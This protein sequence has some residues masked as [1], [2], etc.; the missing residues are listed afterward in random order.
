[1]SGDD[2][3]EDGVNALERMTFASVV[4]I[5]ADRERRDQR[6]SHTVAH[7]VHDPD[8]EPAIVEGIVEAV[9][10]HVVGG[11]EHPGD[12]HARCL[13]HERWEKI[14]LHACLE[15]QRSSTPVQ[16]VQIC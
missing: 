7:R 16:A 14:P 2:L 10:P 15:R 8:T 5:G 12:S 13:E 6:R 1:M 11:F 3:V 9:A 4:A